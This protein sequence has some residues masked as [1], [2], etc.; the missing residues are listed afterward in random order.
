[1]LHWTILDIK[2]VVHLIVHITVATSKMAD[3]V[4]STEVFGVG[5]F[6]LKG[7]LFWFCTF[8]TLVIKYFGDQRRNIWI[9]ISY[10][11]SHLSEIK[12]QTLR[13]VFFPTM[14]PFEREFSEVISIILHV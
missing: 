14:W 5:T 13:C 4:L 10:K 12:I 9:R 11:W 8:F 7:K 2:L 1:M 6:D 3:T